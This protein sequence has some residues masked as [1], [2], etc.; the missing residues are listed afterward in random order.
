[1]TSQ[2]SSR[3]VVR[4]LIDNSALLITGAVAAL[5]WAN[6]DP[7]SY[8]HMVHYDIT[9][10]WSE[11]ASVGDLGSEHVEAVHGEMAEAA[12]DDGAEAA[13]EDG[14][15]AGEHDA[16]AGH[17]GLTVHF[18]INDIL[19]ALF[20]AIAAKEVWES[21]LPGG[22]LSNPRKAATPLLA[23]AGGILGPA[24]VY[25]GGAYLGGAKIY[26]AVGKGWAIP[27]ATDIAFSYLV[28]RIIFG[29]GHPAIAFLLLLAIA[30]DAAGLMI[31]AVFYPQA[32]IEPLWLL[33]TVAAMG[34]AFGLGKAR[35][36]SHW[37][38]LLGPGALCWWSFF[39]A[40]I[41]PALGLVPIIPL[42]PHAH[43][44]LGLFVKAELNRHDTLN[45]FEHFWKMPVEFFLGAFGLA[46]A[47]VVL[48]S[49]ATGTWLVLAGLLVGKPV[50][51]TAMTLLA[52]K[53]LKLEKPAGMDYRHVVTLGMV[54][55]IG[56]TVALFVSVAAFPVAGAIQDSVK[57][58]ALLSFAAAPIAILMGKSL[59]IRPATFEPADVDDAARAA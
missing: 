1:M 31:L 21:L 36:H 55:G 32:P 38:Y 30:D 14:E 46:N 51:I 33:L 23:T 9:S 20:F 2:K 40:N 3:G 44:D 37:A 6:I 15:H 27:C 10:L 54:A 50:G 29:A 12:T 53:G 35:I 13:P 24:F 28:A 34:L 52:E 39:Q 26:E 58:G 57:M 18:V 59:R 25:L 8:H 19:M 48:S 16:D 43:T 4:T 56:F 47:G 7:D 17:H 49:L 11:H 41:H 5:V 45:E 42:L 22:A